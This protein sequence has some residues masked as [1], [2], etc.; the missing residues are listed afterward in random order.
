MDRFIF[1]L[2]I[3]FA[4]GSNGW[5][6]RVLYSS[7]AINQSYQGPA[8][9]TIRP[10]WYFASNITIK[11]ADGRSQD[12]PKDSVWGY[13]D[14]RGRLY[15]YYKRDFYRVLNTEGLVR[16]S[17]LRPTGRGVA[18]Y[19]YFSQDYDSPLRWT[20]AKARRDSSQVSQ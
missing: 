17:I 11:Y 18:D 12:V 16:Y 9:R 7:Q 2:A 3:L 1:S 8:I 13:E 19:Q 14:Q 5:A 15:R 6:Q 4:F 20:K 10:R